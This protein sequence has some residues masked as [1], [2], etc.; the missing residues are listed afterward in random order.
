M[1][2]PYFLCE[3]L[4]GVVA[5]TVISISDKILA[6]LRLLINFFSVTVNKKVKN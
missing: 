4:H 2:T 3:G 1:K 5:F 6:F